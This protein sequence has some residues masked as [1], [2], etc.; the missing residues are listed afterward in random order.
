ME[1]NRYPSANEIR[2]LENCR[3]FMPQRVGKLNWTWLKHFTPIESWNIYL[4]KVWF[5]HS[6]KFAWDDTA[7]RVKIWSLSVYLEN[8]SIQLVFNEVS[9]F[10]RAHI[11]AILKF[12]INVN[13]DKEKLFNLRA[14]N[15]PTYDE[16]LIMEQS[17]FPR[18]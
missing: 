14:A 7:T 10:R 18:R 5:S 1:K 13:I 11:K 3:K 4:M 9:F 2:W 15:N 17:C 8:K 16:N 12:Q 6:E